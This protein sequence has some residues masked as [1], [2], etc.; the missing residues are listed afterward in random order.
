MVEE[1]IWEL[2][3]REKPAEKSYLLIG[4]PDVGLVGPISTSHMI[5]IF[6]M[7]ELG[8]IDSTFLPPIILFH[9]NKPL[10]PV[11]LYSTNIDG[12]NIIVL[13]S[14]A[15][16][17]PPGLPSIA[18]FI[19]DLAS[20]LK[21]KMIILLGGIAVPNRIKIEKPKT[22]VVSIEEKLREEAEKSGFEILR[23]GFIGGAYALILKES[24]KRRFPAIGL[25]TE[26]FATYPDPGAA[27]SLLSTLAKYI[28]ISVDVKSLLEQ[29]EEIR[30]KLREL[31]KRTVESMQ[32]TG[33]EYEFTIPAMYA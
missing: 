8:Y 28:G 29:E 17:P 25:F 33:K 1:N 23:E 7:K 18:K 19:V 16:I 13:H 22:Y 14:D 27:A 12:R 10:M 4:I 24:F 26:C 2:Y 20:N 3:L 30:I 6:K 9:E 31:M 11:R 32:K 21:T 15:A 5:R